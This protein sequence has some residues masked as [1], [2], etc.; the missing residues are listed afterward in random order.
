[1]L[2]LCWAVKGGSGATVISCALAL[3][4]SRH[5]QA[6]LVDLGGDAPTALGVPEPGGPGIA[7]W[8][9]TPSAG[10]DSLA[11]LAQHAADGLHLLTAGVGAAPRDH[12]RW[13]DLAAALRDLDA[14]VV[15]DAG[16]GP[17]P[18]ALV[19]AAGRRLLVARPCYLGLR[20]AVHAAAAPSGV[21]V[22]REPGRALHADDVAAALQCPVAAQVDVDP[23]VARCVDAGLL[24]ARLPRSLATG[25]ERLVAPA[26]RRRR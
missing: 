5:G 13:A 19:A 17:P 14:D 18:D 23:H 11:A 9:A 2:T 15:V 25:L 16:T 21:I 8:L 20:R 4:A 26:D 6:W 7:D 1:V 10:G 24:A 3:L 12:P 22:V